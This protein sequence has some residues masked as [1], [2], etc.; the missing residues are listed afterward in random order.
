M[1]QVIHDFEQDQLPVNE[2]VLFILC[3]GQWWLTFTVMEHLMYFVWCT[4][5]NDY[6]FKEDIN[7]AEVMDNLVNAVITL[8]NRGA[9]AILISDLIPLNLMPYL[10]SFVEMQ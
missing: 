8:I 1:D 4:G 3:A 6:Y 7:P 5:G 10:Q 9:T 2:E